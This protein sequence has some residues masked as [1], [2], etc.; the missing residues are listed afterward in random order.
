MIWSV[1]ENKKKRTFKDFLRWYNNENVVSTLVAMQK[2]VS[3]H[4][5]NE[6]DMC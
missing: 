5:N 2:M 4:H 3:F 1:S 6:F